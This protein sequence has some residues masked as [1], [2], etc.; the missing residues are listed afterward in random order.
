MDHEADV[1]GLALGQGFQG[2]IGARSHQA[3]LEGAARDSF[4][5]VLLD[6]LCDVR[7]C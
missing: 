6:R 1:A 5:E 7:A 3:G 4:F 2:A